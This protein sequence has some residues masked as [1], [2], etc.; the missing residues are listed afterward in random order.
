MGQMRWS[1][2]TGAM[3]ATHGL[4][5]IPF[6]S[7][8]GIW[9]LRSDWDVLTEENAARCVAALPGLVRESVRLRRAAV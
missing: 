5:E 4:A 7:Y 9:G 8:E 3:K 2:A 1:A 6:L